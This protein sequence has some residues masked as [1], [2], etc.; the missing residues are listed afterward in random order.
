MA[1]K[2]RR[3]GEILTEWGI[4]TAAGVEEALAHARQ[5]GLRIGEALVALGLAHL[6]FI[7]FIVVILIL[8]ILTS[9]LALLL[10]SASRKRRAPAGEE[11]EEH[12]GPVDEKDG[13]KDQEHS[14]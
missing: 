3:I 8:L 6:Q 13:S 12:I 7:I 2:R 14:E 5:E 9:I 4:V 11:V 1:K 10:I